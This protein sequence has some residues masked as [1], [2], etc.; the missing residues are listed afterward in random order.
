[1]NP[2]GQILW[3]SALPRPTPP[4]VLAW[5]G[6]PPGPFHA[7]VAAAGFELVETP[8]AAAFARALARPAAAPRMVFL[9]NLRPWHLIALWRHGRRVPFVL[10]YQNA[11]PEHL[12][13]AKRLAAR[14]ALR[15]ARLVLLQDRLCLERFS[16]GLGAHRVLFFPWHVD[17]RFFDPAALS[18]GPA[19]EPFLFVPGDRARLDDVV[20]A[21]ARRTSL[22]VLR[23]SRHFAPGVVEAYQTCPNVEV[24]HF[25]PWAELRSLYASATAVLN[26]AD[27]SL[28]SAG[29]TTLLEALAMNARVVTPAG[30]SSA[31]FEFPDGHA[32]YRTVRDPRDPEAWLAAV[33]SLR[34]APPPPPARRPRDLVL[35]LAGH[36]ACA[37]RW[38]QV[39]QLVGPSC[40]HA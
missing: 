7:P 10:Y 28:T 36:A 29:M 9:Y 4:E 3:T 32:P 1:M 21:I 38:R 11:W 5:S 33:E 34:L 17:D 23:V 40:S 14:F 37:A 25:V 26:V 20:L 24:R 39:F 12:P 30:H 18:A 8:D 31:G 2:T 19:P 16:T 27:D 15:R 6:P 13:L 22:R 35:Q